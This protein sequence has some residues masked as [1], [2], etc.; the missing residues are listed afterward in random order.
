[1]KTTHKAILKNSVIQITI[2]LSRVIYSF[3]YHSKSAYPIKSLVCYISNC[4]NPKYREHNTGFG[5]LVSANNLSFSDF[6]VAHYEEFE[7]DS[8]A[9]LCLSE[10]SQ[11][12]NYMSLKDM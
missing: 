7:D 4:K 5:E 10:C 2:K 8:D 3:V 6:E 1:M 9:V 12:Y 11:E